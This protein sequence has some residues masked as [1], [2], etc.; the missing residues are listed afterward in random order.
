MVTMQ[1]WMF[2]GS[3]EKMRNDLIDGKSIVTMAHLGPRAFD[4]IGGEVVSVTADVLYNGRSG[5]EGSYFRL[6]DVVGSEPK[7]TALLEAIKTPT[8]T[9]STAPTPPPSMTSP[10]PPSPTGRA[11]PCAE[12]LPEPQNSATLP[13]RDKDRPQATTTASCVFIGR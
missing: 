7:R 11:R 9:G 6:V 5:G 1:S 10:A 13:H 3:F 12:H 8:A 2:L 4:A